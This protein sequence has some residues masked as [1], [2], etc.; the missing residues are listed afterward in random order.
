MKQLTVELKFGKH[1]ILHALII[2]KHVPPHQN[3]I[4]ELKQESVEHKSTLPEHTVALVM[5]QA[6]ENNNYKKKHQGC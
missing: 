4:Y 6:G 1:I 2:I 5:A 3:A